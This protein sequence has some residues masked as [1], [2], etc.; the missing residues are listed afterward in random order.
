[1]RLLEV[2]DEISVHRRPEAADVAEVGHLVLNVCLAHVMDQMV[3]GKKI[4]VADP[5][6]EFRPFLEMD[7]LE[8]RLHRERRLELF[9]AVLALAQ[10]GQ[11]N[12]AGSVC[13]YVETEMLHELD[14]VHV[15][16]LAK[17]TLER[18]VSFEL[19][20]Q[21]LHITLESGVEVGLEVDELRSHLEFLAHLLVDVNIQI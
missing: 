8:V 9:V 2:I 19:T 15:D 17:V 21:Y 12:G 20:A 1:V 6:D 4:L 13:F 18:H 11:V 3:L 14:V 7:L 16:L 10:V 5:A